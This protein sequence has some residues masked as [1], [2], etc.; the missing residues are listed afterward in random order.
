MSKQVTVTGIVL[1]SQT[2]KP[3]ELGSKVYLSDLKGKVIDGIGTETNNDGSFSLN[4]PLVSF[5]NPMNPSLPILLPKGSHLGFR[6]S[7]SGSHKTQLVP[8][9]KGSN[10]Y[11]V[12]LVPNPI[13]ANQDVEGVDIVGNRPKGN[14][15]DKSNVWGWVIGGVVLVALAGTAYVGFKKGWFK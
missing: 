12:S 4:V 2:N 13:G 6:S 1:D 14:D 7:S 9:K 10:N 11:V 5:N 3:L 15:S 8:I